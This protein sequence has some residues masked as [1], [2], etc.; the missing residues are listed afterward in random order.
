MRKS[1]AILAGAAAL[2][3]PFNWAWA[4]E[5]VIKF[6]FAQDFT[7]VYTFVSSEY[8]HGQRDYL[9]LI[10]ARGG[11]K[12]YTF[13]ATVVDH[14]NE[15]QRGIEAYERFKADG[16][17]LMDFFS[18]PVSRAIVPRAIKE[19]QN[20]LTLF[21]GR[22]DAAD[23]EI[24][25]TIFPAGALY[26]SQAA[27]ILKYIADQEKGDLKGK[28]IALVGIDS[29]FGKEPLPIFQA[30]SAK[31]GFE[32]QTFFY[33]SPGNEQSSS[34]TAVRRFNP[35]WVVIWGAG[36]GQ[37]VSLRDAI[38]NGIKLDR[39]LSVIW[40]SETDTEIVGKDA[41]KGVLRFEGA[42][43]GRDNPV[44]K[45]I[46]DEVVAKGKSAGPAEK[47]A[48]SYYNVGV[49]GMSIVV[50][51]VRIAIE[52]GQPITAATLRQGLEQV[53]D[54]NAQGLI[55]PITITPKDHQG[56]GRGRISQWDGVKWVPKTD[57]YPA[58]Q[59]VVWDL[60]KKNAEEFKKAN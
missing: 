23:G 41:A 57:W 51:A 48:S 1:L 44:V 45:A 60:I 5:K 28:K 13:Q 35:D 42:A 20:V 24:F 22:S 36:G 32:L 56:G 38:R 55:P 3:L 26:W 11:I 59:D 52:K 40:L 30:V 2:T 9:S 25:P 29:P 7:K 54:F 16:V 27:V 39:L 49:A 31:Q 17:V 58:H 8:S 21:H 50:E 47:V 19:G 18:T 4:Q 6:G 43:Y 15:P 46:L 10:N 53:K 33:P 37:T 34:W 14:G 12:G